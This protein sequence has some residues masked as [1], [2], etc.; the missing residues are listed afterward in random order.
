MSLKNLSHS[1]IEEKIQTSTTLFSEMAKTSLLTYDLGTLDNQVENFT[2]IKNI[3]AVKVFD[4]QTKLLSNIT[5]DSKLKISHFAESSGDTPLGNRTF[6]LV[7]VPLTIDGEVLGHAQILFEL[8]ES[9]QTIDKNRKLTFL[10]ILIEMI[11]STIIAYIIGYRLTNALNK[12]TSFAEQIAQNDT[13]IIPNVGKRGDEM[14]IL[15][16]TLY[17]MQQRIMERNNKL[18][19]AV[20]KLK[21]EIIQRKELERNLIFERNFNKT[22]VDNANAIIAVIDNKGVMTT[23]NPYAEHFIGYS[24][25]EIAAEPYFWARFLQPQ[26]QNKVVDIIENAK[27]GNIIKSFQNSWISKAGEERMFEWSN[28]LVLNNNREMDYLVTIGIDIT[29]QKKRQLELEHAK[30]AA[31]QAA[32]AK[33][34]FLANMSHEIRTPMNAILG[35]SQL[36]FDTDLNLKQQ[37]FLHKILG[38]SKMLLGIINDILDYSK[39]EANKLELEHKSFDLVNVLTQLKVIFAQ[40]A[41]NRELELFLDMENDLPALLVGDELRL[42]QILVNLL[43]NALKFT[44]QGVVR[45]TISLKEK[46]ENDHAL[47]HFSVS[48]TGIGLSDTE[49]SK[50]FQPFTQADNSTTRKYGGTGLGLAISTK[51]VEAM[52]GKLNVQ[53]QQG[54]GSTFSFDIDVAV[55]S[56]T[57]NHSMSNNDIGNEQKKSTKTPDLNGYHV[58]LVEDNELNQEVATL[59]LRKVGIEVKTAKNG[60]EAVL[61]FLSNPTYFDLILMDLQMPIMSGY[62]A[63]AIIRE[64]NKKVPIIALT[65]A[66]MVEDREKVLSAGMNDHL[67]KPIN[68]NELYKTIGVCCNAPLIQSDLSEHS[69]KNDILDLDYAL[70]IVSGKKELLNRL[71]S[72]LLIQ[73]EREFIDIG[74]RVAHNDPSAASTIHAL[75]GV[76][77]N[78]GAKA[79]SSHCGRIDA[80]LKAGDKISPKE[81]QQLDEAIETLKETIKVV[82]ADKS[83]DISVSILSQ[84]EIKTLFEEIKNNLKMGNMIKFEDQQNLFNALNTLVIPNELSIW[85]ELVEEFDYDK[86][87]EVMNKW[88]L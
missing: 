48:D 11:I 79:L 1:L 87:L 55:T 23:I 19:D 77:G 60:K 3:V 76:S 85:R 39:I 20:E 18:N 53:S 61:L 27:K 33:S 86:A 8:T 37:D 45:L 83:T 82:I 49:I 56:W 16:D 68:T 74:D 88:Q 41:L 26:M 13:V 51:L 12:L 57:H 67:S 43:S 24:Q 38:S 58:L 73:L 10:L 40:I 78:L 7:S 22:L 64:H 30:E 44:H 4:K 35:L 14:S 80:L 69:P 72:K 15:S 81:A 28:A 46:R 32:K 5:S 65:A 31:E 36:M 6:R 70:N 25:Q 54:I 9:L 47:L 62:E 42:N 75:K 84:E 63:T 21:E 29:E 50:L 2:K 66:A 59:M 71:L 34:N 52:G 17:L